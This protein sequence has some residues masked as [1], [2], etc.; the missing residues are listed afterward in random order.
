MSRRFGWLLALALVSACGDSQQAPETP[1]A[2]PATGTAA[3]TA[4]KTPASPPAQPAAKPAA[5]SAAATAGPDLAARSVEL[6]NPDDAT[7]V[8][9]Y[10]DLAGMQPPLEQWVEQDNR[11]RLGDPRDRAAQR[12]LVRA[13]L[14]AAAAAVREVGLIRLS[15][16]SAS[17]SRYD[18]NYGEF[19]V[20][21]LSPGSVI[22]YK[23]FGQNV[24]IKFAN[25]RTAQIW[26]VPPEEGQAI[27]DRLG[28]R[29][30]AV[31]LDTLLEIKSVVPRPGG[32]SIMTDITEYELRD[33]QDNSTIG[34][35]SVSPGAAR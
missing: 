29:G 8:L 20:G 4:A 10:Y 14:E 11:V 27:D 13:E 12:E 32:G 7:V 6:L 9:L 35:I 15:L 17:L 18:P 1:A 31:K 5:L 34:R 23:A 24:A 25:G 30:F 16:Q 33:S 28:G 3:G 2:A 21:A 22:E 26:K 19:I